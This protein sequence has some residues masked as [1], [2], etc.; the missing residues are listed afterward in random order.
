M[1]SRPTIS[2]KTFEYRKYRLCERHLRKR[3]SKTENHI[4]T[5]SASITLLALAILKTVIIL[6]MAAALASNRAVGLF[7]S[8]RI[9]NGLFV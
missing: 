8:K 1:P 9:E 6:S 7:M 5:V 2:S 3:K 4:R